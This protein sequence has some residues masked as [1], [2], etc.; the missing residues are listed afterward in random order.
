MV[1]FERL[2][3]AH[4]MLDRRDLDLRFGARAVGDYMVTIQRPQPGVYRIGVGRRQTPE[5][6]EIETLVFLEAE[7]EGPR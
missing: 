5:R 2:L 7:E 6:V 1:V 3:V 4:T